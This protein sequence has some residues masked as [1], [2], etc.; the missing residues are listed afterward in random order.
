MPEPTSWHKVCALREDLRT[1]E[2]AL[3]DFAADLYDVKM[4]Q[5][6]ALYREPREFFALTYPTYNLRELVKDVLQRLAGT[7]S[8]PVVQLEQ[9]YGGGKT[10][11]LITLLHLVTDPDHLPDLPA[12]HEFLSHAQ[13]DQAPRAAVAV[14][15]FDKLDPERGMEVSAPDGSRRWFTTPWCALAYQIAGDAGIR[16]LQ[17]DDTDERQTPPFENLLDELVAIPGRE[18]L[19]LLILVDEVLMYA[20]QKANMDPTWRDR[21][22]D[23]F[24]CLGQAVSKTDRC[25]L[26]ASLLATDPSKNDPVGRDILATLNE[27]LGRQQARSQPVVKEDVAEVLRRRLF[28]PESMRDREAFR[29]HVTA[30]LQGIMALDEATRKDAKAAEE[31]LLDSYPFNPDLTEVLY[32]KWQNLDG[33]QRTR[34]VLRTFAL[35]LRAAEQWDAAPLIGPNVFLAAPGQKGLSEAAR[36]LAA[37]AGINLT[38]GPALNWSPILDGELAKARA[39]DEDFPALRCRETEQTVISTFLHSQPVGQKAATRDL[40]VL[41]GATRPD[42]I[43]LGQAMQRWRAVS[44]FLDEDPGGENLW[45]LGTQPNL[46]QMHAVA[47]ERVG[48]LVEPRLLSAIEGTKALTEGASGAGA[49][50]H[51]LPAKPADI[52]DDGEFH[53]AILAPKCVSDSGKPSAAAVRF[54]RE[55]TGPDAPRVFGNAVVAVCPSPDG[56]ELARARV[57]ELLGWE[58][59]KVSPEAKAFSDPDAAN[60]DPLRVSR[61]KGYLD[62]TKGKVPSA[63]RHAYCIVVTLDAKGEVQAFKLS[64][65][66]SEPLFAI[67][68]ADK[69]SRIQET[70]VSADALLPGGP[71][72]LWHA[73]DTAQRV[74]DLAGAFAQRPA[75]PKMLRRSE[76][77]ATLAQ[78]AAEGFFVLRATRPDKSVRTFWRTRVAEQDMADPGMEVVLLEAAELTELDPALLVPGALPGLWPEGAETLAVGAATTHFDGTHALTV[79]RGSYEESYLVPRAAAGVVEAAIAD[80]IG[81]GHLWLVHG[82]TSLWHETVPTE[83]LADA[84]E[85]RRPPAPVAAHDLLPDNLPV[86]WSGDTT[87]VAALA[88]ALNV[89]RGLPQPWWV[90]HGAVEDAFRLRM[91]ERAPESGPW[92][93]DAGGAAGVIV[94]IPKEAPKPPIQPPLPTP[95]TYVTEAEVGAGEIANLADEIGGILK[96]ATD[97]ELHFRLRIEATGVTDEKKPLLAEINDHLR[98]VGE[99]LRLGE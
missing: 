24:Q 97:I 19:G 35:A 31:R 76:I 51:L 99:G 61:L 2:L 5:G 53:F 40:Q 4:G 58:E 29:A 6:K 90:I 91:L 73:G 14:L 46:K 41:V 72:D 25:A 11:T 49:A 8:Q 67:V 64:V 39:I 52:K 83:A 32:G 50:N 38:E 78:G 82:P 77:L 85:L 55:K 80:A 84:A 92:P 63:I 30:A 88:S 7:G 57:R 54:L 44:W 96:A 20:R 98:K 87:T 60:F 66:E 13:L 62:E 18:G 48:D 17:G 81:A 65:D 22:R 56:L 27:A 68:K 12:V 21:L 15:P 45:R 69:R 75:L 10:H 74:K 9:T 28:A 42:P 70:A 1:G 94:R 36:E 86:A 93:C 26:V 34:G 43:E 89:A 37:V 47:C 79:Q 16:V 95:G 3:A 59:V 71:Y 33:F 23:F